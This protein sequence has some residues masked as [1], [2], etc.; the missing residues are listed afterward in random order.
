MTNNVQ[1]VLDIIYNLKDN[2]NI[3]KA[4][5]Y[6]QFIQLL[7]N[8]IVILDEQDQQVNKALAELMDYIY[9]QIE[10]QKKD[11]FTPKEAI[12][13]HILQKWMHIND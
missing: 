7:Y 1:E 11:D 2:F 6:K 3:E 9:I 13:T 12:V 4:E 8:N 10:E 5:D